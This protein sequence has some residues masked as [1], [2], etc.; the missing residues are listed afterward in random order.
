M[1]AMLGAIPWVFSL[2]GGTLDMASRILIWGLFGF[3]FDILFGFA[4]LLSFGQSAFY[5]VGGFTAAYLLTGPLAHHVLVAL[6][7]A[8]AAASVAGLIVGLLSLRRS[9]I[10]FAM[11][12]VAFAQLFYFLE[13]SPLSRWTGGENGLSGVPR[14][15]ISLGVLAV[16]METPGTMY[17]FV[18]VLFFLSF[19]LARR[20][21]NSPFGAVLH[22]IRENA[23]R[24]AAVGHDVSKY[25]LAVFVIAAA[26]AGLAGGLLGIL[27]GY[28]PPN[29]FDLDTS[30][31]LIMQTVI[32][33]VGTLVGPLIGAGIWSFLRITLQA[34]PGAGSLWK[35]GLG[36]IFVLLIT[37][38][39]RGVWGA[40]LA[41][42]YRIFG[43][44]APSSAQKTTALP[45]P[46]PV[47]GRNRASC[48]DF[49]APP[50][51]EARALVKRYGGLTAVG[52]VSLAVVEGEVRALIGPNGAG[53]S[54][55]FKMLAGEVVPTDGDVFFDGTR[56]TALRRSAVCQLGISKSYQI[57][58][59]FL[60]LTVRE[61]LRIPI[62]ARLRGKFRPDVFRAVRCLPG[63]EERIRLMLDAIG[64]K[65]RA[66]VP[67]NELAYGEKRRLEIGL[68]LATEP[69]ILLLDE[70]M[71]GM[72][73]EERS[74][75]MRLI[76]QIAAG[77]TII[78]VE[79]DMDVVFEL[80]DRITVLSEGCKIAEG[81][82][83]AIQRD[84]I[85]R[86]AYL[87]GA[88][89]HESA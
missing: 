66:D 69:R 88:I 42:C 72:S 3:G 2:I 4:G 86:T 15:M 6:L 48:P 71:A 27:Q 8:I 78:I 31:Q 68:A 5:G 9:G 20:I 43:K 21:V 45:S 36:I 28:M 29:A 62:L 49:A 33:G 23:E 11:L 25:K 65:E 17:A 58:Q 24:A 19:W 39:R 75:M 61:N 84:E 74:D 40:V 14:P 63:V 41:A 22:A 67:A 12:T 18:A 70:P 89:E 54:T 13:N 55:F 83:E 85:V 32:G 56:I 50:L 53:K 10:Y 80:A 38:L 57:N 34:V 1:L 60:R 46:M 81:T 87:G 52:G 7:A 64:L 76:K 77:A 79:H 37:F 35:L 59:L 51:L 16:R 26:Y 44:S 47:A 73:P 30:G 82:P